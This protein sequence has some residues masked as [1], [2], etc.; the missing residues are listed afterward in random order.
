VCNDESGFCECVPDCLNRTCGPD[1]CNGWCG[2]C[3]T[4]WQCNGLGECIEV[5]GGSCLDFLECKQFYAR[6]PLESR[7]NDLASAEV[8]AVAAAVVGCAA[9][10]CGGC[11]SIHC[12][13]DCGLRHCPEAAAACVDT[14]LCQP[15]GS[16]PCDTCAGFAGCLAACP[17]DDGLCAHRCLRTVAR[18][19]Y[20]LWTAWQ[21]CLAAECPD[22]SPEC[23]A[24]AGARGGA[25]Q[26]ERAECLDPCGW[27]PEQ[28]G[29]L[30]FDRCNEQGQCLYAD[31]NF[32]RW[33]RVRAG[34]FTMGSP[35]DEARRD[36]DEGAH[37]VTL[38][39]DV[40]LLT[41]EVLQNQ[42]TFTWYPAPDHD[43]A[44][45]TC[46]V[47]QVSYWDALAFANA[48]SLAEGLP[49]C[50]DLVSCTGV[51]GSAA[52][53]LGCQG[54]TFAGPDCLG[55]RLPT[56]AEWEYAYR[57]GTTTAFHG[58]GWAGTLF[59]SDPAADAI[60]WYRFTAGQVRHP[61]GTRGPNAL[62]LY[63]LAGNVWEWV[64]DWYTPH[65]APGPLR[66]E[67]TVD[68]PGPAT[69]A[70]RVVR[71]GSFASYAWDVRAAARA[72]LAPDERRPDVGLRLARTFCAE[73]CASAGAV[74]GAVC[75]VSCGACGEGQACVD[76]ACV[77]A[78]TCGA[79]AECGAGSCGAEGAPA[80]CGDCP[81][82]DAD[83]AV[84]CDALGRCEYGDPTGGTFVL[85]RPGTFTMGSP[86]DEPGHASDEAQHTVTL[87]RPYLLGV[88][89]VSQQ[90]WIG[91]RGEDPAADTECGDGCA[92]ESVTWFDAL[93]HAN[94]RSAA[95]GLTECYDLSSCAW[96]AGTPAAHL[97]CAEDVP[98]PAP[99]CDGWRLP[100]EAEWE[101][102]YRAGTTTAFYS[103]DFL[104]PLDPTDWDVSAEMIAWYANNAHG[105]V[106]ATRLRAPNRWALFELAGNVA[107]WVWDR[108]GAYDGDATDPPGPAAG[109]LRV[110]RGGHYLSDP[111]GV[112]AAARAA[113]RPDAAAPVTGFRLARTIRPGCGNGLL[114]PGEACDRGA[115]NRVEPC[116]PG[117]WPGTC[118]TCTPEC[119]RRTAVALPTLRLENLTPATPDGP[120]EAERLDLSLT[121][122][123]EAGAPSAALLVS[124]TL[125]ASVAPPAEAGR[126]TAL[127]AVSGPT[128]RLV[129]ADGSLEPELVFEHTWHDDTTA[130]ECLTWPDGLARALF[131]C[132]CSDGPELAGL[133]A[134]PPGACGDPCVGGAGVVVT[135]APVVI[136]HAPG[137][138]PRGRRR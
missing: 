135:P 5:D 37:P 91:L 120:P 48:R 87:T 28:P 74:C 52:D 78:P 2:T 88:T 73:T 4:G 38:T 76:G 129:A 50:Y 47:E 104:D 90:E 118:D 23:E 125:T 34:S 95:T 110:Q 117:P 66:S 102:A 72:P 79:A 89:E 45:S 108:Y 116:D 109:P 106:H 46:P 126:A 11:P 99:D 41:T 62:G 13:V 122:R 114:E 51:A 86:E 80:A 57:A 29:Q 92:V 82:P 42:W 112:R 67:V 24:A 81:W 56:E 35:A 101:Y 103:G 71:G 1:G 19:D 21:A 31:E 25:C 138:R 134:A 39:R 12:Q 69:G 127:V 60:A 68:P 43:P 100:T 136:E 84:A 115:A 6:S 40:L 96:V 83:L 14:H 123:V 18:R 75:G 58:G 59:E 85:V 119:R 15:S 53:P 111:R 9:R 124:A 65:L 10:P 49:P 98:A 113:D 105:I 131:A 30:T 128:G 16:R 17:A 94:L 33:V 8:A 7:C 20:D 44:C 107:E 61:G 97:S 32:G 132:G 26:V 77:C 27:C 93:G 54:A 70:E 55:Y 137:P 130:S 133:L 63:D 121:L 36:A 22:R 64:G 3:S